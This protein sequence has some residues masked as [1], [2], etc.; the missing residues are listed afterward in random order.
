[1]KMSEEKLSSIQ[2]L[3]EDINGLLLLTSH[4]KIKKVKKL[5][6]PILIK[7]TVYKLDDRNN[8]TIDIAQIAE[9]DT[10]CFNHSRHS[11]EKR[12]DK[13]LMKKRK[14][15]SQIEVRL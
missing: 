13:K 11:K 3:L 1:M 12:I 9:K 8:V 5:L 14:E 4:D 10:K 15:N 6:T 2:D 7:E